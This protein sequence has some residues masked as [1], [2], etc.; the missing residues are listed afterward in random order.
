MLYTYSFSGSSSNMGPSFSIYWLKAVSMT[1]G[2]VH[3]ALKFSF[4]VIQDMAG[5]ILS[6]NFWC[7]RQQTLPAQLSW[8]CSR[9]GSR[10]R[11][12]GWIFTPLFLSALLSFFFFSS[13]KYWNDIWFLWH[14]YKN[15]PPISKSWIRPCAVSTNA[16]KFGFKLCKNQCH[17][18]VLKELWS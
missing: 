14:Y 7:S 3:T 6:H 16:P 10:G 2:F 1:A 12:N 9:C 18:I 13:L 8:L 4:S 11:G 5:G 17:V 15:S